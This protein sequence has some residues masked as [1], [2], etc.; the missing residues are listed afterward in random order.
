MAIIIPPV[1]GQDVI[2]NVQNMSNEPMNREQG[3]LFNCLLALAL[4]RGLIS[5]SLPSLRD[6]AQPSIKTGECSKAFCVAG[7]ISSQ[8]G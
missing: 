1:L 7:N 6:A 4:P 3:S 8:T 5:V 2:A